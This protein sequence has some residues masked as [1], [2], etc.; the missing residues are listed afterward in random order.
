MHLNSRKVSIT[1][2]AIVAGFWTYN[3]E[4]CFTCDPL[5]ALIKAKRV[6]SAGTMSEIKRQKGTALPLKDRISLHTLLCAFPSNL[7]RR[8]LS[9]TSYTSLCP[10][11][12]R[13]HKTPWVVAPKSRRTCL[14]PL[15]TLVAD[16]IEV[17]AALRRWEVL[18]R[19]MLE[20]DS[21]HQDAMEGQ[22]VKGVPGVAWCWSR[23]SVRPPT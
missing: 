15:D 3:P 18:V 22:R 14:W 17:P 6:F 5:V 10:S 19:A 23:R 8:P 9:R 2:V 16:G 13:L 21:R 7:E 11:I 12:R 20:E 4:L 1:V